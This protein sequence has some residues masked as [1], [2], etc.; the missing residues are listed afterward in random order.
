MCTDI[1]GLY[2]YSLLTSMLFYFGMSIILASNDLESSG[3]SIDYLS[4]DFSMLACV[5]SVLVFGFFIGVVA[6]YG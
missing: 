3:S 2:S 4:L 1:F 5:F 6:P